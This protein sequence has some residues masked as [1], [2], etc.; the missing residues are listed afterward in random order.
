MKKLLLFITLAFMSQLVADE[1]YQKALSTTKRLEKQAKMSASLVTESAEELYQDRVAMELALKKLNPEFM[2]LHKNYT[3][4]RTAYINDRSNKAAGQ[5]YY[6]ELDKMTKALFTLSKDVEGLSD[7]R[8]NLVASLKEFQSNVASQLID[9]DKKYY[10]GAV[11]RL[12]KSYKISKVEV[13]DF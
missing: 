7:L 12:N 9:E 3:A 13:S 4:L 1:L 8:R 10:L 6:A 5:A 2:K 11:K